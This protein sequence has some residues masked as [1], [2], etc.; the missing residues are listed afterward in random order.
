[1]P[2]LHEFI[3]WD[4][5]YWGDNGPDISRW[6][7]ECRRGIEYHQTGAPV[8]SGTK[9]QVRKIS[10]GRKQ[11]HLGSGDWKP[12]ATEQPGVCPTDPETETESDGLKTLEALSAPRQDR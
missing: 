9:G 11:R 2:D 4:R 12:S 7:H 8:A 5:H 1:M 3:G 6:G 10:T